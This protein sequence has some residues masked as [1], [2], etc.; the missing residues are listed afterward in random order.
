MAVMGS[1]AA[2]GQ[3]KLVSWTRLNSTALAGQSTVVLNGIVQWKIG[4]QVVVSPTGYF[5]KEGKIWSEV[6]GG[7]E[8]HTILKIVT[9]PSSNSTTLTLNSPLNQTHLCTIV[10]GES[11]CGVVGVLTHSV[12][13]SSRDSEDLSSTSYGFGGHIVVIDL[14]KGV[15]GVSSTFSGSVTLKSV[16]FRNLGQLNSDRYAISFSYSAAHKASQITGCSF[17]QGYSFAVRAGVYVRLCEYCT[18]F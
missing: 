12:K 18:I 10:Q 15:D 2:I 1:F 4:D 9:S 3:P 14:I 13:V 6:G 17:N 5:G 7:A 16:E 8:I 11:F